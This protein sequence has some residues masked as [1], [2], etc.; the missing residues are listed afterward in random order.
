MVRSERISNSNCC[1]PSILLPSEGVGLFSGQNF[2][3][4]HIIITILTLTNLLLS[5]HRL[6]NIMIYKQKVK[7]ASTIDRLKSTLTLNT[8]AFISYKT[9]DK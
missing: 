7:F 9:T 8:V 3:T 2:I 5:D 4:R 6:I 1:V